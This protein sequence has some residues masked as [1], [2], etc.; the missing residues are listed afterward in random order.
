MAACSLPEVV[1]ALSSSQQ[2]VFEQ[3]SQQQEE[4]IPCKQGGVLAQMNE[5]DHKQG[6][7]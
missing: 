2:L 4:I 7:G 1:A 5:N 3:Q 6:R